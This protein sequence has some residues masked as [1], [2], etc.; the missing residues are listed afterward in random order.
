MTTMAATVI[1]ASPPSRSRAAIERTKTPVSSGSVISRRRAPAAWGAGRAVG[2]A[3]QRAAP[4][5]VGPPLELR[6]R[7]RQRRLVAAGDAGEVGQTP[8]GRAGRRFRHAPHLRVR[9]PAG[10]GTPTGG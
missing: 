8:A 5:R 2:G 6:Q 4:R 3:E 9:P 10:P 1:S 7:R